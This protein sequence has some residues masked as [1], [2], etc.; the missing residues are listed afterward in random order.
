MNT[1]FCSLSCF[2]MAF[3]RSVG[4]SPSQFQNVR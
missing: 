3:K 2:N 4:V 1:G